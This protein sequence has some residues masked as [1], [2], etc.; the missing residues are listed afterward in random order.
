MS[1]EDGPEDCTPIYYKI[2]RG[3]SR[4]ADGEC[5]DSSDCE[6]ECEGGFLD[7]VGLCECPTGD[8]DSYCDSTC[9]EN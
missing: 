7:D 6:S 9:R 4:N 1:E 8:V 2:C 5:A 3:Q